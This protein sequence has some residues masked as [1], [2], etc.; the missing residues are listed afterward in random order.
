MCHSVQVA[1]VQ[2]KPVSA[3]VAAHG[4]SSYQLLTK[5]LLI[6]AAVSPD[7]CTS[8]TDTVCQCDCASVSAEHSCTTVVHRQYSLKLAFNDELLIHFHD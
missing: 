1:T 5:I 7:V 4:Q 2:A 3:R 8:G 6:W